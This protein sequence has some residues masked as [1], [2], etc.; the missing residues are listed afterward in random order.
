MSTE[1]KELIFEEEAREKLREG[2]EK[3]ADVVSVTL[4]PKGR[5]VGLEASYGSPNITNDGHTVVQGIE[6][7]DQYVNMG[8]SMAKEVAAKMKE[9]CGDGTTTSILL[10]K[11]LVQNGIK[12]IASGASPIILKRG[13]EK[14]VEAVIA[15]IDKVSIPIQTDKDIQNI[16]L[17][18]G[19]GDE[20]VGHFI[21][22]AIKKTGKE[23]VI[24]IEEGKST[25]T[26]IELVEGMQFDRGY[27][28]SYFCTNTE[29]LSVELS[30]AKI[31]ITDKKI[32]SVQEIL[33]ILQ[34][35]A[36]TATDFLIIADDI[37]G[38]ALSTLV[39]N[40]LRGTLKV[41]AVKAPG[42]GDR[43]QALLED[44]AILTGGTLIS[45]NQGMTLQTASME[46]LGDAEKVVITKDKTVLVGGK[47]STENIQARITQ[48][49]AEIK[50]ATSSY[51]KDKLEERKAKLAGGVAVIRIGAATETE[52]KK[53]K[54]AFQ[55]SLNSTRAAL[56]EGIV[57]GGGLALLQASLA[58]S[59]MPLKD[60]EKTGA[61]IVLKACETP[62]RQIVSNAGFDSSVILEQLSGLGV[63]FGFNA[64]N[65]KVEDLVS[66]GVVDP[67]KVV[68]NALKFAASVAGV[69]L[70]SEV[71]IGN[72]P[73]E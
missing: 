56:A 43:R 65:E 71:L 47:G 49:E 46:S 29:N 19:S 10:L 60:E 24:T 40:K 17:I 50:L 72:A 26:V 6:F 1:A 27:T 44:I 45:E 36:T 54:Q 64:Q 21:A 8:A 5:S 63:N 53:K 30:D 12:N 23:G 34:S 57:P 11:S 42:F 58:I 2:I 48:I 66:A 22:E 16:A 3:L 68:K 35:I 73:Q 14:A 32:S 18:S 31:L 28:S 67:A 55:D 9:I 69:V 20:E 13:M 4:G 38:D 39:V 62:F 25:D 41:C 51:D 61:H 59:H 7:K 15:Q 52:M 33:T 70:I 37:E